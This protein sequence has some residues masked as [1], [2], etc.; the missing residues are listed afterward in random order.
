MYS[1]L[2]LI[3]VAR[4]FAKPAPSSTTTTSGTSTPSTPSS[5]TPPVPQSEID[6]VKAQYAEKQKRKQSTASDKDKDTKPTSG[7]KDANESGT[8]G[9]KAFSVLKS[10]VSTLSSLASSASSSILFPPPEPVIPSPSELLRQEAKTAK[11][12]VLNRSYFDMRVAKKRREWEIKDAKERSKEWSFPTV[13]RGGL[14]NL[15]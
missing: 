14:P 6:K 9:G 2:K 7:S 3:I 12:F 5:P 8:A 4:Q 10:S 13:P 15:P 11:Q 1:I